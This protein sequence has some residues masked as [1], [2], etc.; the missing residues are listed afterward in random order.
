MPATV[1]S[2][3]SSSPAPSLQVINNGQLQPHNTQHQPQMLL[4]PF[5]YQQTVRLLNAN[6]NAT[7]DVNPYFNI[8]PA[9]GVNDSVVRTIDNVDI[10]NA[11]NHLYT[12][13]TGRLL[14][15]TS[16]LMLLLFFIIENIFGQYNQ[17]NT[18]YY[19]IFLNLKSNS[20]MIR[21]ANTRL[22]LYLYMLQIN[23]Q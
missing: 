13:N 17:I 8:N 6:L 15:G 18:Y 9:A 11:A 10:F 7:V 19:L 22:Q 14:L 20:Q 5:A 12:G 4:H 1:D 16:Y 21:D 3:S 23:I 2:M